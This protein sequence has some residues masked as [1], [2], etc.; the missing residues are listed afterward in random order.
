MAQRTAGKLMLA[1]WSQACEH[2]RHHAAIAMSRLL[3]IFNR[4]KGPHVAFSGESRENTG[5]H[6]SSCDAER[7][8]RADPPCGCDRQCCSHRTD[9][10]RRNRGNELEAASEE[11]KWLGRRKGTSGEHHGSPA[12]RNRGTG[13]SCEVGVM[14]YDC[15]EAERQALNLLREHGIANPPV[16][17]EA[18]AESL[19]V[20]VLY[21]DFGD[22]HRDLISGLIRFQ[23]DGSASILVNSATS[24]NRKTFTIAHELGHFVMHKEWAKGPNYVL[25]RLNGYAATKP[26]E[27]VEADA[28][29]A[30]LLV[31]TEMLKKYSRVASVYE[32]SKIFVVSEQVINNRLKTIGRAYA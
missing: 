17:P 19:G 8:E 5:K 13:R 24:A 11:R 31:P 16:D 1:L 21:A 30:N 23:E 6:G 32:L 18:I 4:R 27:E 28:F 7:T 10:H 12:P 20:R 26:R 14:A 15:S 22:K 3:S 2:A 25:P 29:A 9:S